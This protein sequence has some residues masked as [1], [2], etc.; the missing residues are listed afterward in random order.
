[1]EQNRILIAYGSSNGSTAEIAG[2]IG[3]VLRERG[4]TVDVENAS[5]VDDITPYRAVVLGGAVYMGRWHRDARR[6]ARRHERALG[7]RPVWIF[8]SGPLDRSAD[9]GTAA[10]APGVARTVSRLKAR[11]HATFGGRL[12]ADTPGIG[13]RMIAKRMTGDFRNVDQIRA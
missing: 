9:D 11:G 13:A 5:E 2:W 4:L 6:L 7:G 3:A 10:L 12:R 1:M 8:S